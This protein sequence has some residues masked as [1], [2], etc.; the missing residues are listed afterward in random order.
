MRWIVISLV[1]LNALIFGW[2]WWASSP[3]APTAVASKPPVQTHAIELLDDESVTPALIAPPSTTEAVSTESG[4]TVAVGTDSNVGSDA[5]AVTATEVGPVPNGSAEAPVQPSPETVLAA[6]AGRP[7]APAETAS[8]PGPDV[9]HCGWT[10]WQPGPAKAEP[11]VEAIKTETREQETGRSYLV[12]IPGKASRELT[13][14]RLAELKGQGLEAAFL[15][16]G[17]QVG[18]I[19][20]GLFSKEESLQTKLAE[21]KAAGI[22]DARG[23]ERIR[24]ETQQRQLW[25]WTGEKTPSAVINQQLVSCN[26]VAPAA[27]GQ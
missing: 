8:V 11:A 9:Q 15:N 7:E 13:L 17:P 20:L 22:G 2:R 16:K 6:S 23:I 12:Y 5:A 21:L 18:G 25:R 3:E 19:S 26:D 1:L 27:S 24:T 14:A 4:D 10:E